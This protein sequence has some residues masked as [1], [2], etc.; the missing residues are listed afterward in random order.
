MLKSLCFDLGL[1]EL[2]LS[3]VTARLF[4]EAAVQFVWLL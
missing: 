3:D 1:G 4:P 2:G